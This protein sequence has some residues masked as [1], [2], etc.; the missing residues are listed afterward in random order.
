MAPLLD[1]PAY[2]YQRILYPLL[3]RLLALGKPEWIPWSL[4]LI[5]L[6]SI[7][8]TTLAVAR[9][10]AGWGINPW[11]ALVVGLWSGLLLSLLSDLAEPLAFCLVAWGLLARELGKHRLAWG[12]FTLAV[13]AKEV[14]LVFVFALLL[15]YLFRRDL[16]SVFALTAVALL[17]FG[18]FQVWLWLQF[19]SP[20][21]G[22]GGAMATSFEWLPFMGF[23]RIAELRRPG[24]F[25]F[26]GRLCTE[27]PAAHCAGSLGG[28]ARLA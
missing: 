10:L 24:V 20:G 19:G 6:V 7:P 1:V 9:L 5:G 14:T 12:L 26:F 23:W 17:P 25:G 4:L 8:L 3:A 13:F 27:H 11:Y 28:P 2:R 21:I 18:L 15:D 22:S 16:R